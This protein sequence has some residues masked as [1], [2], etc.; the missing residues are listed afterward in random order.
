M[1]PATPTWGAAS[2]VCQASSMMLPTP[3][4]R[5]L[6][7]RIVEAGRQATGTSTNK[8]SFETM[9]GVAVR[10]SVRPHEPHRET[11]EG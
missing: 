10:S 3:Q 7:D 11:V 9:C 1:D 5:I 4:G 2:A 8:E 6:K